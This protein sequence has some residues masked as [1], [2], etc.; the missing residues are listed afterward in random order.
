MS[1]INSYFSR[2][3][4]EG[5]KALIPYVTA[6]DPNPSVTVPLLHAMVDAGAD[7]IELGVPFSDPMAD[8]PVIQLACERALSHNVRLLD[9][10]DM[11]KA[12]RT[13]NTTTPIV[14]MG[15]LNP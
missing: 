12:F 7:I 11:V 6:G 14:L 1:R 3:K 10:L 2:L 8:G 5:K 9:V 4:A 15:Y 13:E